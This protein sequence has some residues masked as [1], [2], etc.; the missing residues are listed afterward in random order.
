MFAGSFLSTLRVLSSFDRRE[1]STSMNR[2][3]W[4]GL[5]PEGEG[6]VLVSDSPAD[7]LRAVRQTVAVR[8]ARVRQLVAAHAGDDVRLRRARSERRLE[9]LAQPV[10]VGVVAADPPVVAHEP[11]AALA[12]RAGHT[13]YDDAC[14]RTGSPLERR[15]NAAAENAADRPRRRI[16]NRRRRDGQAAQRKTLPK[17]GVFAHSEAKVVAQH[18]ADNAH[19]QRF[20]ASFEGR[21]YCWIEVGDG[22]AG[23]A[24]GD[25]YAEPNP[26]LKMRRPGRPLHWGKVAFEKWWL[27]HWL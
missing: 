6:Q 10:P 26:Q 21:G 11:S 14:A 13:E 8:V 23:F 16:C 2:S 1:K 9:L 24:G 3:F 4:R 15:R 12:G 25:F 19:G 7:R 5:A 17:A 22:R 18:I 27:H 20:D